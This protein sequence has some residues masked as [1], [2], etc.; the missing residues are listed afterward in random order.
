MVSKSQRR[1]ELRP[2]GITSPACK[3]CYF[4]DECGG[5]QAKRS[6][7]TCFEE[8][9]CE[10]TG[11]DKSKCNSVCPYKTD[12]AEWVSETKGLHFDNL[13]IIVQQELNLPYYVPVIYHGSKRRERLDYPVVALDTY[14]TIRVCG[15]NENR[16]RTIANSPET[17]REQ[18]RIG[19]QTKVILRGVANDPPLERW[20]ENRLESNAP[21]QLTR[22]GI[23]VAIAPNFS[24]FLGV[25]RTDNLF[26]RRRQLDCL[27]E[28]A[29]AGICTIPHLSAVMPSDWKFWQHFLKL[30]PGIQYVAKEFQTGNSNLKE[31]RKAIEYLANI[32]DHL[33]RELHPIGIGAARFTEDFAQRFDHFTII[34][35]TPFMKTAKAHQ[36]FDLSCGK[37]PWYPELVLEG[38]CIDNLLQHNIEKY[39]AW[40]NERIRTIRLG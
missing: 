26:N 9:C 21:E 14:R 37:Q 30:A 8:T 7:A 31:G 15:S 13:P 17:L 5:F 29:D 11:K 23:H 12:F 28:L 36:R 24:H 39:A 3:S 6:M 18:F 33:K 34:D 4:F 2:H 32:Q 27:T 38:M 1:A 16:Y 25:P 10:F 20:W 19:A 40:I 35:S 22:L